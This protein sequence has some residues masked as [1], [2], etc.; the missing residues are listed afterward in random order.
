MSA[1]LCSPE[2]IAAVATFGA[3][4]SL[5]NRGQA[6][7]EFALENIASIEYRYS[8]TK[9]KA[10]GE[11]FTADDGAPY[12]STKEYL[13]AC[14]VESPLDAGHTAVQ[15]HKLASCLEYQSCE[16]PGWNGCHAADLI[17]DVKNACLAAHGFTEQQMTDTTA[18]E[19]AIWS[20]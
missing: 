19:N 7:L 20:I 14:Q 16:H 18:W 17:E 8:D 2:H 11:W 13:D 12:Y 3:K 15:I 6:A 10:I 5:F 9:G 4:L 1:F